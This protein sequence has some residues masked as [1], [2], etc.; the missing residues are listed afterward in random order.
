MKAHQ[1]VHPVA[2]QGRVLGLSPSGYYAWRRRGP[3]PRA[4]A[5]AGLT[6]RIPAIPTRSRGTSGAPRVHAELAAQ[7]THV[8]R[9]RIARLMR[10]A[11]VAGVS[12]RRHVWTTRRDPAARPAPDLV[13]RA[14]TAEGPNRLWV[15]DLTSIATGAGFLHLAVVLDA[16]SRR[17][18]GWAMATHL[19]TELVLD[20]LNM[21]VWQ[22]RPAR[23][24]PVVATLPC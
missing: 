10:A 13:Q 20:A 23:V 12:R 6:E 3:S 4:Q 22:R 5:D 24:Q 21:A 18:V 11:H 17:V 16:W 14:F 19:R 1:A 9:K 8:G 2:T 15:A 7:G